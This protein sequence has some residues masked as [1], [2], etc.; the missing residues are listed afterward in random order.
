MTFKTRAA[1]VALGT[2]AVAGLLFAGSA[3]ANA[4]SYSPGPAVSG[5]PLSVTSTSTSIPAGTYRVGICTKANVGIPAIAPACGAFSAD[6][7]LSSAGQIVNATTDVVKQTGNVNA[8]ASIPGQPATFNCASNNCEV[9]I[10]NH[11]TRAFIERQD[12]AF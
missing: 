8:H 12:L 1:K 7:V 6:V 9:V 5:S 11:A 3:G 2:V 10:V 4:L